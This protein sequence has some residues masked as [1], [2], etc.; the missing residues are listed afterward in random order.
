MA[1]P[2]YQQFYPPKHIYKGNDPEQIEFPIKKTE[3][4]FESMGSF[5]DRM[6]WAVKYGL[7]S[8]LVWSYLD[9]KFLT[10]ITD[11]RM[12]IART[13][14]FTVPAFAAFTGYVAALEI[15]KKTFGRENKQLAYFGAAALPASVFCIWRKRLSSFPKIFFPLGL[16][17]LF[18]RMALD[19]NMYFGYGAI[20]ENPNDPLDRM[21]RD[22]S[23]FGEAERPEFLR[24]RS[25]RGSPFLGKDEGPTYAKWE[26]AE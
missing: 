5:S 7:Y 21:H 6:K 22:S 14:F 19:N 10:K 20:F 8:G 12:Q 1:L 16:F 4:I 26:N 15:G 9:V 25:L 18:Y 17:G 13:A 3:D 11:R 23:I 2:K 24:L